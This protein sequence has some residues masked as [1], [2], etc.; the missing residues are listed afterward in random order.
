MSVIHRR[1]FLSAA[2]AATPSLYLGTREGTER[3]WSYPCPAPFW[4][5]VSR[6]ITELFYFRKRLLPMLLRATVHHERGDYPTRFDVPNPASIAG[7]QHA[8]DRLIQALPSGRVGLRRFDRDEVIAP[9][10]ALSSHSLIGSSFHSSCAT[11]PSW[12]KYLHAG[13]FGYS[14]HLS[15]HFP[16]NVLAT[17]AE[18][19]ASFMESPQVTSP[20]IDWLPD[21]R[22]D[23]LMRAFKAMPLGSYWKLLLPL[24]H[25]A[26][27]SSTDLL[28]V[29]RND[30]V[31][32]DDQTLPLKR[33][34]L[35][36]IQMSTLSSSLMEYFADN[37]F[38]RIREVARMRERCG[39][40]HC[41]MAA[42]VL[43]ILYQKVV[44]LRRM[45]ATLE[46]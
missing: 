24:F 15:E 18:E 33:R 17:F 6:V 14:W 12:Q 27:E 25:I 8:T 21:A 19:I 42:R 40:S 41:F 46:L 36:S 32:F 1:S 5:E 11:D 37:N 43:G 45:H 2:L 34:M 22:H 30:Q 26:P 3:P 29:R 10:L 7:Y 20:A 35:Y 38:F 44:V 16:S 23:L 9:I 13:R 39:S 4:L 28:T 31:K